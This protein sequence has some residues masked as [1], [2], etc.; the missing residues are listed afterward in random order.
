ME[1][2]VC[3][4]KEGLKELKELIRFSCRELEALNTIESRLS[5]EEEN[6]AR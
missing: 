1:N 6:R 2:R 5:E 3:L 4:M